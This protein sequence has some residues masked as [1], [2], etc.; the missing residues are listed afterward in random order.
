MVP[1][2]YGWSQREDILKNVR[3][4]VTIDFHICKKQKMEVNGY[5]DF[6]SKTNKWKSMVTDFALVPIGF[7]WSQK[8]DIL[9]NVRNW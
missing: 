1:I 3:N 8:E 9:K 2:G 6:Y 5:S 4:P 7:G